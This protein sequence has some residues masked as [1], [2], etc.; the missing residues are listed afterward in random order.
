MVSP[1]FNRTILEL[2]LVG[3][4]LMANAIGAFN[5]TILELKLAK[6]TIILA[7]DDTFNRTILELKHCSPQMAKTHRMLLIEPFWN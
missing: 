2:K 7:N 5:R 3:D 6:H 4:S 1:A